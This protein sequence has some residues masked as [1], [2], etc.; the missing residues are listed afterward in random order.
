M[1]GAF[2]VSLF[3][4]LVAVSF[5]CA[6]A[7]ESFG[8]VEKKSPKNVLSNDTAMDA[9]AAE[10]IHSYRTRL[11]TLKKERSHAHKRG[12]G[13]VFD[14]LAS[15]AEDLLHKLDTPKT[16]AEISM[17]LGECRGILEKL[18]I[19]LKTRASSRK[20]T[21]NTPVHRLRQSP[22]HSSTLQHVASPNVQSKEKLSPLLDLDNDALTTEKASKDLP[23]PPSAMPSRHASHDLDDPLG[24]ERF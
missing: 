12:R 21:L 3:F 20:T 2:F 24:H 23:A 15:S 18:Q 7:S 11:D 6:S 4:K 16:D 22:G 8:V 1:K 14:D 19:T 17:L 10:L 5:F 13:T 9:H